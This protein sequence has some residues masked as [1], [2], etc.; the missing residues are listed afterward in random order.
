M[1]KEGKPQRN[2]QG[3]ITQAASYQ[4][5]DVPVARIEPNRKWFTNT[6]VIAQDSLA[7]FREAI[8]K[9][10][11]DPYSYLLKSNKLP[12]SLIKDDETKNGVKQHQAK[13][14]VEQRPF[15][16]TFG[17]KAHRK[18]VKLDISS[19]DD[20]AGHSVKMYD[21]YLDRQDQE[22][23]LSGALGQET[24]GDGILTSAVEP[25]FSKGQ[26]KRIWNE[27]Y[28]VCCINSHA[29]CY[30]DDIEVID[31]SDVVIHVL[32]ARDPDGTRCRSVE[33]Y[34]KEEAPHKHLLFV[35]N[36]CDLIPTSVAVSLH[37]SSF[38]HRKCS[39]QDALLL[40]CNN[41]MFGACYNF[42]K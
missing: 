37:F 2:A 24:A 5:R 41:Q 33:K 11:S 39:S 30:T 4:S 36:K 14:A 16:D 26:S 21:D 15:A 23:L 13:I 17:P 7:Q 35:L 9:N 31:S 25:I 32:D 27:L 6:R 22:A 20:L 38:F 18:R 40:Y 8:A 28:K 19:I 34:I 29:I 10:A 12:M 1:Y 42:A 3:D